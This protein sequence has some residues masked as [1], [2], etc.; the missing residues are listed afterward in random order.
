MKRRLLIKGKKVQD[1]GYRIFLLSLASEHDLTGFQ[2]RNVGKNTVEALYEG[3]E[4]SIKAF[5]AEV[6]ELIPE[7]AQVER[8]HFED[9][10]GPVKGIERFRSYFTTLQ[11]GKMIE[12][13]VGM[14][15]KQEETLNELRGVKNE[16][17]AFREESKR[18]QELMLQKQ[19]ETLNEL[20]GVRKD[21]ST[22]LDERLA[23]LEKDVLLIKERLGIK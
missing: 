17:R 23:A 9:Y 18:N 16:L 6:R 19:E 4:E 12:V 13:G 2:A 15:Q 11:L 10:D 14:L 1:I 7:G 5:E 20:R 8:I 22:I 3:N 21:L